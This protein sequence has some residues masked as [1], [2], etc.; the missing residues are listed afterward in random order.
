MVLIRTSPHWPNLFPMWPTSCSQFHQHYTRAFFVWIFC[1]SQNVTRN[2]CRNNACMKNL[3]IKCWWNWHLKRVKLSCESCF[4]RGFT[5]CS[6][7]F[8]VITLALANQR[9]FFDNATACGKRSSQRSYTHPCPALHQL[10]IA[11]IP[12]SDPECVSPFNGADEG[13][14]TSKL[15][16]SVPLISIRDTLPFSA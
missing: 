8:K 2:S 16:K 6:C 12:T 5:A 1:Q 14:R 7:V 4:Q 10:P 11:N 13:W 9:N 15:V 3:Y